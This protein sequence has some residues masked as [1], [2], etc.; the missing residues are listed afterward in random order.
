[1]SDQP[2]SPCR[3]ALVRHGEVENPQ[4][5]FYGRLPGF[6]LSDRGRRQALAAADAL[7]AQPVTALYS[8][9][10]Q[11]AVETAAVIRAVHPTL[12]V[13]ESPL[14]NEVHTPFDG[15]PRAAMIARGWDLYTGTAAEY[16][17]P[18]AVLARGQA[19]LAQSRASHPGGYVVAVTHGDLLAFLILWALGRPLTQAEKGSM[20]LLGV[21]GGYPA[22]ASITT[23]TFSTG[24]PD[25]RPTL[26]YTVPYGRP[27]RR[28][29][30]RLSG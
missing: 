15:Q 18:E 11:R 24:R 10:Q 30:S 1:M 17:Q 23:L 20:A 9:P 28:Q 13:H 29:K 21:A 14:L 12:P 8:S 26:A 4:H 22:P 27:G 2:A 5:I 7:R 25:E 3:I 6:R 19:F 16:E